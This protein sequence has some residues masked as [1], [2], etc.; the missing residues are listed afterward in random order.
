[1]VNPAFQIPLSP[2]L[3]VNVQYTHRLKQDPATTSK[4]LARNDFAVNPALSWPTISFPWMCRIIGWLNR[5]KT[6]TGSSSRQQFKYCTGVELKFGAWY[7]PLDQTGKG[8]QRVEGYGDFSILIPLAGLQFASGVL[9][10][11]TADDYTKS[12]IRIKYSD[13]VNAA[14]NYARTK[15]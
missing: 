5:D 12:R 7:L 4:A 9:P 6:N 8:S 14:N 10:H 1:L 13:A 2:D 11:V 3:T 15:T